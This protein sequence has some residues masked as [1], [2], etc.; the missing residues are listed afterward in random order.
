MS[1]RQLAERAGLDYSYL[2]RVEAELRQASPDALSRLASALEIPVDAVLRES[3]RDHEEG[4]GASSPAAL[5]AGGGGG[6]A[7]GPAAEHA[8]EDARPR[9]GREGAGQ[10]AVLAAQRVPD[11]RDQRAA[12]HARGSD[13]PLHGRPHPQDHR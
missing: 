6:G 10:D 8:S 12:L 5:G 1:Q 2:S 4:D 9:G 3:P 13:A 11:G 7:P